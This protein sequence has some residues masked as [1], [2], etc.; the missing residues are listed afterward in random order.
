MKKKKVNL[1]AQREQ[2]IHLLRAG[3]SIKE[4]AEALN[5]HEN[6]VYKWRKRYE[7]EGWSGLTGHSQAPKQHGK[8][9]SLEVRQAI[10]QA[11]SELEAEAVRGEGLKYIGPIA[12][13]TRLKDKKVK[14][15]PSRASIERVLKNNGMTK[16]GKKDS[17]E[18]VVKYPH[19]KP[20]KPHQLCQVDIVPH[21][22]TGG[23]RVACFNAVDVVSRYP[24]G[25]PYG[26]R[27]SQD[28]AQFLVHVWQ[29]IGIPQYTQVDNEGCFSGGTTHKYVLGKVV[30]L[31][32]NVGTE[33]LF[34]PVYHPKSNGTV[35]RFH[36]D[37]NFHVWEGTYL[38]DRDDVQKRSKSF[39]SLYRY[40]QII[41]N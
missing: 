40:R 16:K 30:R 12:V 29:E 6:W 27:R 5:R 37:Y 39:F 21:F 41:A 8:K 19:L 9:L 4:V 17:P 15:L 13:K 11:R 28:A 31:A 2:A 18:N 22:L 14:E 33:L 1:V 38:C 3:Q 24:T 20:S 34:S 32:L 7:T 10:C 23:E 35:E 25:Q 26:Q 36:Q